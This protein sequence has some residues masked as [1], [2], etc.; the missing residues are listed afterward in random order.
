MTGNSFDYGAQQP[1]LVF[2][3]DS[4]DRARAAI[5]LQTSGHT[6]AAS[7]GFVEALARLDQA[8]R[9]E[10]VVVIARPGDGEELDE[11]LVKL[12]AMARD[13]R[14]MGVVV[15]PEV[16]IDR[17]CVRV[18]HPAI[19]LLC[20]PTP[21]AAAAALMIAARPIRQRAADSANGNDADRLLMLSEEVGRIA[22]T[23]ASLSEEGRAAAKPTRPIADVAKAPRRP[24]RAEDIR[25]VIRARRLRA[26][27]FDTELF[28][29]PAWDMLLDLYAARAERRQV[30]V[31]SLCIA[32]AV[33][34]T[35]ALRWIRTMSDQDLL[36]RIADPADGRRVFIE[37]S[38]AAAEAMAAYFAAAGEAGLVVL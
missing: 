20:D 14:C 16:M 3:N 28:A 18:S 24:I 10:R 15:F 29:D 30:A 17:V 8:V 25:R 4:R 33:P 1:F 11:L 19:E 6:A 9:T 12:E 35:T 38:D 23:L 2:A 31:S 26:R 7:A 21:A 34:P 5:D 32:S 37:L 22:R 36:V 13:L 27:F